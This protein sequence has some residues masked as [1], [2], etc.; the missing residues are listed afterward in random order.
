MPK[1]FY[2]PPDVYSPVNIYSH[3]VRAGRSLP[4]T[5]CRCVFADLKK[6]LGLAGATFADVV[7]VRAYVKDKRVLPELRRLS[8]EVFGAN[9]PAY[10]PVIVPSVRAEGAMV[11][12][13]LT[14][15]FDA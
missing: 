12:I 14:V 9:R 2:D 6:T 10:T 1:Q 4:A 11:E 13:E 3:G 7:Y 15:V 8:A 5:Q